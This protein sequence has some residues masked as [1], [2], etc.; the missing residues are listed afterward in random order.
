MMPDDTVS[1]LASPGE[2]SR[3][4]ALSQVGR[5]HGSKWWLHLRTSLKD[6]RGGAGVTTRGSGLTEVRRW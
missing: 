4:L 2:P 5:W 1:A 6:G 3:N